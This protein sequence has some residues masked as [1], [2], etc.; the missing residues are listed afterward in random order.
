[1]TRKTVGYTELEW[2]CPFCGAR[3]PGTAEKC[4]VCQAPMPDDVEFEQPAAEKLI[5]DEAKIAR[6]EAGPDIHC[7]FCGARNPA[8]ATQ[9]Q[10]CLAELNEGTR[11]EKGRV[12][13]AH[14]DQPAPDV[15]CPY[16][17]AM[18]PASA[19]A[20]SQ[21]GASLAET[22]PT[23]EKQEPVAANRNVL[24]IV[25]GIV[26]LCVVACIGFMVLANRTTDDVGRVTDVQWS[27][28][29]A[30]EAL[31]PVEKQDWEDNIPAGAQIRSCSQE[32]RST[33]SNPAPNSV[34]VCGTP[35][36]IDTGTGV[37]QVVQD[38]EYQVYDDFCTFTV[39][40][41]QVVDQAQLTGNDRNPNWPELRLA[42]GQRE[43]P[44]SAEYTIV[45]RTDGDTY[46]YRA[47]EQEF[48]QAEIGSEWIL[49]INT[50]GQVTG[51][52]KE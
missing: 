28:T 20:C 21:C 25:L 19:L 11:R 12:I 52:S 8:D 16:C 51:I 7:P 14:R 32:I 40:E 10:Q 48:N 34:E 47:T 36:T 37:G 5:T 23:A 38:C 39:E 29:I 18:N 30:I 17:G 50:F 35:Y 45:F 6:A 27:R 4:L 44:R 46:R 49:Q 41:W 2:T 15:A 43:G 42:S 26:G 33:Q 24:W 1:M 3:N 13:G 31:R 22:R 9:C